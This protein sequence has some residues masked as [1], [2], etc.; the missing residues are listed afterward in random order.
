MGTLVCDQVL[1]C[2]APTRATVGAHDRDPGD[3]TAGLELFE[4]KALT[5]VDAHVVDLDQLTGLFRPHVITR[6]PGM[7]F[8]LPLAFRPDSTIVKSDRANPF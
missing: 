6:A 7:V 1:P 2:I 3:R 8:K 5:E 4:A